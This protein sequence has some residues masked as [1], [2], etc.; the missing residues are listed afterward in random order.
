MARQRTGSLEPR[1]GI[2]HDVQQAR[3]EVFVRVNPEVVTDGH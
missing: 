2:W 1:N 3:V